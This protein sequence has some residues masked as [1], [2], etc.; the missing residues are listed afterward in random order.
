MEFHEGLD[1][2]VQACAGSGDKQEDV[3]LSTRFLSETFP[4]HRD[5]PGSVACELEGISSS[6]LTFGSKGSK[7]SESRVFW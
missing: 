6:R 7:V 4:F 2:Q 5:V 3:G 1:V